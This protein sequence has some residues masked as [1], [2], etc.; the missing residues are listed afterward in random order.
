MSL[1]YDIWLL[2]ISTIAASV[3]VVLT[4]SFMDRVYR[5]SGKIK[6][7][8]PICMSIAIGTGIW[9]NHFLVLLGTNIGAPTHAS[10]PLLHAW[11]FSIAIGA[12]F[13]YLTARRNT[14][15]YHILIGGA[16]GGLCDFGLFFS[17]R[18]AIHGIE[19]ITLN[20]LVAIGS[21]VFSMAVIS[22]ILLQFQWVKTYSGTYR[23]PIRI[24]IA[25]GIALSVVSIHFIFNAAFY[26]SISG[27]IG[28]T[29]TQS[30]TSLKLIAIAVALGLICLFLIAFMFVLF[31]E[32][33]GKKL[34]NFS[35]FRSSADAVSLQDSLTKLPNREAFDSHLESA[36]KRCARSG[37]SFA[38][39]YIDLDHFKP[40]NDNYGHHVGDAVLSITAERL[41][42]AVRGC[43]FVSRIGG[44]EFVAIL[45]EIDSEEDVKPI[46]ERI[47]N[48]I[49]E[50][51]FIDHIN[52]D[53][54]CSVGLAL[55]PKD[56]DGDLEKLMVCADAAMYKAKDQ[57]KNQ[58][59]FYDEEIESANDLMLNLQSDLCLA[60]ENKEFSV[61]YLPKIDCKTLAAV[62]VEALVRWNHPTKG[63]ILPNDFLPAAE[64]FGLINEINDWV[65]EECCNMMAHAKLVDLDFNISINLSSHQFRDPNLVKKIIKTIDHYDIDPSQVA[66]EIK[67]TVAINNQKQFKSLLCKFK[68]VGIKVV[69]D[70]FG[71]LPMSLTYLIDLDVDE[72]KLDKS[73]IAMLNKDESARALIDATFKLTHALG[74][75]ATAEGIEDEA[76]QEAI[77]DLGCDYMQG[78]LFSKP[79]KEAEIF[80]LYKK[81][82][83]KQLQIDFDTPRTKVKKA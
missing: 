14:S 17:G 79:I 19:A 49:R 73:F 78:Y 83:F 26:E 11:L 46:A 8:V 30:D 63:E 68:E 55:Y 51:Y 39:A 44:D 42:S 57:G 77:I 18:V 37:R 29:Q 47:V 13:V 59:R 66:F 61:A 35:L 53:I 10:W 48:S 23:L 43:D 4:F 28:I 52:V 70:D 76:Q 32:K 16:I 38:I 72:V 1:S 20:P 71:L 34:L 50:A 67:E 74:F 36:K 54:S 69:L 25:T 21:M 40:I 64:H 60:I 82:Q 58:Y 24:V 22:L 15:I 5:T 12:C 75:Q 31:Y 45:E 62:G 27:T 65:M 6:G 2:L 3:L 33:Q 81:L 7:I 80:K 56:G 9:V 41:N